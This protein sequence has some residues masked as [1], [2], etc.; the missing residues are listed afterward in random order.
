MEPEIWG[1]AVCKFFLFLLF[2]APGRDPISSRIE[3][4]DLGGGFIG[5]RRRIEEGRGQ[6]QWCQSIFCCDS[7]GRKARCSGPLRRSSIHRSHVG[8]V[9]AKRR[10]RWGS[11]PPLFFIRRRQGN[12]SFYK[13]NL[14]QIFPFHFFRV[15]SGAF[16]VMA[17]LARVPSPPSHFCFGSLTPPFFEAFWVGGLRGLAGKQFNQDQNVV[18]PASRPR[19]LWQE[20]RKKGGRGRATEGRELGQTDVRSDFRRGYT[21]L[22][23]FLFVCVYLNGEF[24][25]GHPILPLQSVIGRE[26]PSPSSQPNLLTPYTSAGWTKKNQQRFFP[27]P[28]PPCSWPIRFLPKKDS[29]C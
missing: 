4:E 13:K 21:C 25:S 9:A 23:F 1:S 3:R 20:S 19:P 11:P 26:K 6:Y 15:F 27:F 17:P 16:S 14:A 7:T 5:G 8:M 10:K 12:S 22:G 2:S 28:I 29:F 18:F 24:C